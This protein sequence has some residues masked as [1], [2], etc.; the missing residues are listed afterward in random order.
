MHVDWMHSNVHVN[1]NYI[2]FDTG[3]YHR[4][5]TLVPCPSW[6]ISVHSFISS[7]L[8]DHICCLVAIFFFPQACKHRA[9]T[10]NERELAWIKPRACVLLHVH[11][12]LSTLGVSHSEKTK[13]LVAFSP[14]ANSGLV[15]Q[16]CP[17]KRLL[18]VPLSIL[19]EIIIINTYLISERWPVCRSHS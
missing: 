5:V 16:I 18:M 10:I 8:F 15:R 2:L 4:V 7:F 12:Q 13:R 3:L 6:P 1:G 19:Y 11:Y 17:H 14:L 9:S